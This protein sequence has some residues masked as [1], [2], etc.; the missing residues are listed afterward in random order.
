MGGFVPIP[1]GFLA[2]GQACSAADF[3]IFT[4]GHSKQRGFA[5]SARA[6]RQEQW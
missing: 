3:R 4:Y 5:V 6:A 1:A 2:A